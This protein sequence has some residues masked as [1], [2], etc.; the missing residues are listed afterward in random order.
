MCKLLCQGRGGC[1]SVRHLFL[2]TKEHFCQLADYKNAVI[3]Y[4]KGMHALPLQH[5]FCA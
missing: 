2:Q 5:A 4:I 3:Y 1:E